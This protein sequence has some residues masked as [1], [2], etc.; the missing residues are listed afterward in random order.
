MHGSRWLNYVIAGYVR[1]GGSRDILVRV[2]SWVEPGR[3]S[4][5]CLVPGGGKGS[6]LVNFQTGSGAHQASCSVV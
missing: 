2:M 3:P 5:C 6:V 4:H 1:P